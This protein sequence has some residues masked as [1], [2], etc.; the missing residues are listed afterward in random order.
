MC[1][2]M[3]GLYYSR[4]G[5]A[6]ALLASSAA[7]ATSAGSRRY[8]TYWGPEPEVR[9][10]MPGAGARGRG[11]GPGARG[12]EPGAQGLGPGAQGLGPRAGPGLGGGEREWG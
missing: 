6:A 3:L 2:A 1:T 10:L 8:F 9:G 7:G 4:I 11:P 5:A 12:P